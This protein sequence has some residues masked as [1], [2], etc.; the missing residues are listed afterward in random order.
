MKWT[1]PLLTKEETAEFYSVATRT[2]DR[3]W[4]DG[5]IP[6]EAKVVIGGTVRFR[7]QVLMDSIATQDK[8]DEE[9]ID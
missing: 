7:T 8:S 4:L 2:I 3:W 1:K 5:T 6:A 9:V